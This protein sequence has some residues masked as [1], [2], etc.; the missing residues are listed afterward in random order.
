MSVVNGYC[1]VADVRGQLGDTAARLD[2]TLIERAISATSRG[3]ERYCHRRFWQDPAPAPRI[4]S[5]HH[6]YMA[7]VGDIS[8]RV[9]LVVKT[10]TYGDGSF[11]TTWG[12]TD[13]QL[14]PLNAD[15]DSPAAYSWTQIQ[16]F[17]GQVFP[18]PYLGRPTLQV[19]ARWGWSAVPD[20]INAAATLK[21]V[22]LF[23]R[24]DAPY[25]IAGFTDF[26]PVRITKRDP[27]VIEL[28]SPFIVPAVA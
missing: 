6:P 28:L 27:D 21:A 16:A 25:G 11:G 3:V 1:S 23:M 22:S 18:P 10:D 7:D 15:A 20:E 24:K 8:T 19:T 2:T 5:P 26:G 9:G 13:F 14:M 4:F 17:A 12:P